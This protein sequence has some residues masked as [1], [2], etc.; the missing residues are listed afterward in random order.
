MTT[1]I[2]I[3]CAVVGL[4][5]IVGGLSAVY[6]P[7]GPIVLGAALIRAAV[8]LGDLAAPNDGSTS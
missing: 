8:V 4:V 1:A 3:V 7:L 2:S 5:L 6:A